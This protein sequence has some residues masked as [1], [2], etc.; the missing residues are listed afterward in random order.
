MNFI[1]P[2]TRRLEPGQDYPDH[3]IFDFDHITDFELR[4]VQ[5]ASKSLALW[6]VLHLSILLQ[7]DSDGRQACPWRDGLLHLDR[8]RTILHLR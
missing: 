5:P 3:A 6:F 2:F 7:H 8:K 1:P 4:F